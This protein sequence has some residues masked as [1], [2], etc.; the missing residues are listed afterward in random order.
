MDTG[1]FAS[2]GGAGDVVGLEEK[3]EEADLNFPS[4]PAVLEIAGDVD[5]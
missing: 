3:N 1:S 4:N 2:D 5:T